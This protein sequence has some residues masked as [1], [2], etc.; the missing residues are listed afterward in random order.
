[1]IL[2]HT[3]PVVEGART[4]IQPD[5][6]HFVFNVRHPNVYVLR[7][8]TLQS[9]S[10]YHNIIHMSEQ[11]KSQKLYLPFFPSILFQVTVGFRFVYFMLASD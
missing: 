3:C 6:V 8:W 5:E 11:A 2:I 4:A 9:R 7:S 1:M 10:L